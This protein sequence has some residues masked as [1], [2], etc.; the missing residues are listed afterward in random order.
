MFAVTA[1]LNH[2]AATLFGIDLLLGAA[3]PLVLVAIGQMFVV[4]GSEIDL[5]KGAFAGGL[6]P[7]PGGGAPR[8]RHR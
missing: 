2:N 6:Q 4:G 1:V 3:V 8:R 7:A 5:G